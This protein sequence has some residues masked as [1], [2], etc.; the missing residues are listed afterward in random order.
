MRKVLAVLLVVAVSASISSADDINPPDW[1][2]F[3]NPSTTFQ[4]WEFSNDNNPADLEPGWYNENGTPTAN[5]F[6]VAGSATWYSEYEGEY[7]VWRLDTL[8]S[9]VL[10]IPNT[11]NN[12]PG[13]RKEIWLQIT[14]LDPYGEGYDV[15]IDVNPDFASIN[16]ENHQQLAS[17]Y[18]HDTYNITL[19]PNP[20]EE[21]ITIKQ[22]QCTMYV[23]E[24]VVDTVCIPEP[25]TIGLLGLAGLFLIRK[26]R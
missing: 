8:Y 4:R 18:Y 15:P 2:D 7:G 16:L 13:T 5:I 22:I 3:E 14:Y 25:A 20:A 26:Q 9:L 6:E 12:E 19:E 23:D 11:G 10:D 17:G 24:V 1:R 21:T